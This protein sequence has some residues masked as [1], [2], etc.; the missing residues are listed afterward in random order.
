MNLLRILIIIVIFSKEALTQTA[1][2]DDQNLP[3]P[4]SKEY[5]LIKEYQK[6]ID[7][8]SQIIF[9]KTQDSLVPVENR[10]YSVGEISRIH[11]GKSIAFLIQHESDRLPLRPEIQESGGGVEQLSE[12]WAFL[13]ANRFENRWRVLS[14]VLNLLGER[15]VGDK[16]LFRYLTILTSTFE[17][18]DFTISNFK[19]I[20]EAELSTIRQKDDSKKVYRENLVKMIELCK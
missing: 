15:P 17:N 12:T 6:K 9:S 11:S 8:L 4:P 14:A 7:S 3:F 19:L 18:R 2:F 10:Y 13:Y 1:S 16:K 20:F 5:L